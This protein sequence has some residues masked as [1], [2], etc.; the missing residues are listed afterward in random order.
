MTFSLSSFCF[1]NGMTFKASPSVFAVSARVLR[2][3][4]MVVFTVCFGFISRSI[5]NSSKRKPAF[6]NLFFR[7]QNFIWWPPKIKALVNS[8]GGDTEPTG[9]LH[10]CKI[11]AVKKY[12]SIYSTV[13]LL[14]A[15]GGP[16]TIL[17]T[18]GAVIIDSINRIVF[19]WFLSHVGKK[20]LKFLPAL[21]YIYSAPP[22][23]MEKLVIFIR[24]PRL[25]A[26]PCTVSVRMRKP[27]SPSGRMEIVRSFGSRFSVKA[28]AGFCLSRVYM[29]FSDFFNVSASAVI[30]G[31]AACRTVFNKFQHSVFPSKREVCYIMGV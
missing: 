19:A 3:K 26:R 30:V 4:F 14:F 13:T 8:L 24:T 29:R 21:A 1:S 15:S 22:V 25:H 10:N 20:V 27:V 9:P 5:G 23:V 2:S 18:I 31:V 28:P 6:V 17:R 12:T 16:T 11:L 7:E